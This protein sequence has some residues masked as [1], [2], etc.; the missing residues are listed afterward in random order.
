MEE[1][2]GKKEEEAVAFIQFIIH[3]GTASKQHFTDITAKD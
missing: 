1:R 2:R 3:D